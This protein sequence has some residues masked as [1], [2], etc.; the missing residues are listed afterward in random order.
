[1]YHGEHFSLLFIA[2][3]GKQNLLFRAH[4]VLLTEN[5]LFF[6]ASGKYS[7]HFFPLA[8]ASKEQGK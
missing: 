4:V 3:F 1:V 5:V 2:A 7:F 8:N 6:N